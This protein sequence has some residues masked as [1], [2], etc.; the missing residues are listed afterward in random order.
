M[1]SAAGTGTFKLLRS[2][3]FT[4]AD[5]TKSFDKILKSSNTDCIIFDL[6]DSIHPNKKV[7]ARDSLFQYISNMGAYLG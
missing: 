5:L 3:L 4:P 6:E 7:E 2:V 1:A